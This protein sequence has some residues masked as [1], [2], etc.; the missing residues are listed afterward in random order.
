[1][2][3]DI[4]E[5]PVKVNAIGMGPGI[6]TAVP[7]VLMLMKLLQQ[8][9]VPLVLDADALNII[10][11]EGPPS[12][13]SAPTILTP[14]IGEFDRLFGS[15]AHHFERIQKARDKAAQLGCVIVLK[16]HHTAVCLPD[17]NIW[18]N[19]TG[20]PGM[21]TAGSGDVL[22]GMLTG[23]LAQGY[24]A[25]DAAMLGV[26]LHGLAGD[27]AADKLSQEAMLAGD[28]TASFGKAFQCVAQP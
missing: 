6:G 19:S 18:F 21:A 17:G 13:F 20:N 16:G 24:T 8:I 9:K 27:F 7:T 12:S 1:M 22:T 3:T 11:T 15:T 23:L 14:H 2:L 28:I 10:A 26:F 25:G 4:P 5:I